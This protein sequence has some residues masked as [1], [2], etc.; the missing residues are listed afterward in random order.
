MLDELR[1]LIQS[2]IA[3]EPLRRLTLGL[4]DRNADRLPGLPASRRNHYPFPGGWLEHTLSVTRSALALV[5]RYRGQYPHLRPPLNRDLVAAGAVLHGIGRVAELDPAGGDSAEPTVE[6][7]LF[8]HVVLGR[9]VVRDAARESGDVGP[10]LVRLLEH[11]LIAPLPQPEWTGPRPPVIPEALI[12]QY[13]ADLDAKLELFARCLT[14]DTRP[15]AFTDRDPVLA[16]K[17]LK[18]RSV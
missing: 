3:D 16:R 8:G 4:I 15:G 14:R 10:E 13:A 5:D 6:G 1:T 9:D 12:V 2:E 18:R 17:L 7:R 11:V